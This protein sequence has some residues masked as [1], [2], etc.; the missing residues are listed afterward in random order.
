MTDPKN[1]TADELIE[2]L[3]N[4]EYSPKHKIVE[5]KLVGSE[6]KKQNAG[7][8]T[9]N[10]SVTWDNVDDYTDLL[11]NCDTL[12]ITEFDGILYADI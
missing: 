1:L 8:T 5:H 3:K 2:A 9:Y 7:A 11:I 6:F 12:Y 4:S 10:Y